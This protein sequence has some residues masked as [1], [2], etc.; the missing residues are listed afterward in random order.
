MKGFIHRLGYKI[1]NF[2]FTKHSGFIFRL[3][4]KIIKLGSYQEVG[5]YD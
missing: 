1:Q 5:Y 4:T 2:G 3:G